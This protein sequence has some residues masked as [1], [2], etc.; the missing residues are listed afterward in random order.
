MSEIEAYKRKLASNPEGKRYHR[1]LS[2]S[3]SLLSKT[4]NFVID[5]AQLVADDEDGNEITYEPAAILESTPFQSNDLSQDAS[6]TL[7]DVRNILDSELDRIP[8]DNEEALIL[9]FRG[10]HSD[11][12]GSPV[13]VFKYNANSIAQNKGSFTVRAGV[14][15][16]NSDQTGQLYDLDT[17]PMMRSLF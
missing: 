3:H 5:N 8:L 4:Y 7:S 10:Y 16:L 17:F 2:L 14:P 13:E 9:T 12:L 6:Y 1:T 15:D 11:Y